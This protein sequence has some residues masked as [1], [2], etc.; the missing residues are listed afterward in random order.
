[1]QFFYYQNKTIHYLFYYLAR[2]IWRINYFALHIEIHNR[3]N[4]ITRNWVANKG[5][6]YRKENPSWSG[7]NFLVYL[8]LSQDVVFAFK[9]IS[10]II[11]VIFRGIYCLK[12]LEVVVEK[13][14]GFIEVVATEIFARNG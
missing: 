7:D 10:S 9:S 5:I 11:H 13:R 3:V 2:N 14:R 1:L 6:T 4:H 8:A 12:I